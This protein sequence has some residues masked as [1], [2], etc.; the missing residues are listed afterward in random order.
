MKHM[1]E[2]MYIMTPDSY[3]F[4]RNDNICISIGGEEK[5]SVPASQVASVVFFGKNS[6]STSLLSFCSELGITMVFLDQY[7]KFYGRVCGPV[8]G[9]VL[10]RKKQYRAVDD[11]A[12]SCR[13]VRDILYGKICNGKNVL[14]RHARTTKDAKREENLYQGAETLSNIANKLDEC[15]TVDSMRGVEGAA[16]TAYFCRFD[17][18]LSGCRRLLQENPEARGYWQNRFSHILIDEFQDINPVQ[19]STVKLLARAP[20]NIFAVGDDDQAIYGFRGAE[21]DCLRRFAE[22]FSARRLLLD[23][24]YRSRSEIV[25]A[26][27]AV[28][29]ENKNRFEKKLR[30]AQ[31]GGAA[32]S[33]GVSCLGFGDR[34]EQYIS[35]GGVRRRGQRAFSQDCQQTVALC[36]P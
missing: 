34:E 26:S 27:L 4:H 21:P 2:T 19:Y 12:F 29:G 9:N 7:G 5:A 18:M 22:E 8:S 11:E 17:D 32:G 14:M 15:Q 20:Y 28:I 35:G 33:Q 31:D 30:A 3:L 10:L 13:L 25:G 23:I 16:A 1:L 24:N 6:V 36:E